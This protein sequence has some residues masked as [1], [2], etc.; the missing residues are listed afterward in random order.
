LPLAS[1]SFPVARRS[2]NSAGSKRLKYG[3]L[4]LG[5][6]EDDVGPDWAQDCLRS[7]VSAAL[8]AAGPSIPAR[9]SSINLLFPL[10]HARTCFVRIC[11]C[12][13]RIAPCFFRICPCFVRIGPRQ[14]RSPLAQ[15]GR[16]RGGWQM[17]R[18]GAGAAG[19]ELLP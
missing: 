19:C 4:Q 13:V 5:H 10:S 8:F 11:P 2:G 1:A 14:S 12:F 18:R 16:P 15:S 3:S 6:D 9:S 17:H 7:T